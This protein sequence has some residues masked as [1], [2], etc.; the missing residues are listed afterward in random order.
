MWGTRF[1]F[2]GS[3]HA[4]LPKQIGQIAYKT[5]LFHLQ[6]RQMTICLEDLTY[7]AAPSRVG[8]AKA[9][10]TSKATANT[11]NT[12]SKNPL[13]P[14]L[15]KESDSKTVKPASKPNQFTNIECVKSAASLSSAAA[16]VS[17]KDEEKSFVKKSASCLSITSIS[18]NTNVS[19][20]FSQF[21]TI[22]MI[23]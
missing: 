1:K 5:S 14:G 15:G 23:L 21:S 18:S 4:R 11:C 12:V 13:S 2:E 6:P 20:F 16:I 17:V 10:T 9:T 8:T 22:K 7:L 3:A 19:S